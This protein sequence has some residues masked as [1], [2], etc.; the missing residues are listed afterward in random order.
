MAFHQVD[1]SLFVPINT[2]DT[3]SSEKWL[4]MY[5]EMRNSAFDTTVW[6]KPLDIRDRANQF[7]TDTVNIWSQFFDYYRFLPAALSTNI[8]FD[9]DTVNNIITD[10][11]GRPGFPYDDFEVFAS[12]PNKN[13]SN[14]GTVT[15]RIG[16]DNIYYDNFNAF[17][18]IN[19]RYMHINF[20]EGS[21]WHTVQLGSDDYITITYPTPDKYP[22]EVIIGDRFMTDIYGKSI[23]YMKVNR[24]PLDPNA[25]PNQQLTMHGMNINVYEPCDSNIPPERI[26]NFIFVSGIDIVDFIP[27]Q[28]PN[29]ASH[30]ADLAREGIA[31]LRNFGYRFIVIDWVNSRQNLHTNADNLVALLEDLKCGAIIGD[32]ELTEQFVMMGRSMGGLVANLALLKMEVAGYTSNCY[33]DK[34][35]NVRLLVT[36]DAP[37]QGA[38]IPMSVQK[39]ATALKNVASPVMLILGFPLDYF[40]AHDLFLDGDAAKQMLRQ[41]VSTESVIFPHTYNPHQMHTDLMNDI[42]SMGGRPVNCKVVATSNG[43]MLGNGQTRYWDGASRVAGDRLLDKEFT[44]SG[45]ILGIR[46]NFYG[47]SAILNTNPNGVGSLGQISAGRWWIKIR[48]KWFGLRIKTGYNSLFSTYWEGDM[49]PVSTSAG[50]VYDYNWGLLDDNLLG[51]NYQGNGNWTRPLERWGINGFTGSDGFHWCFIPTASAL[52]LSKALDVPYDNIPMASFMPQTPFDVI[53]GVQNSVQMIT[54]S[55][56]QGD[57]ELN[58]YVRNSPHIHIKNDTLR[59]PALFPTTPHDMFYTQSNCGETRR[60]RVLN[61]EVGDNELYLENQILPCQSSF[62]VSE[63]IYVNERSPFYEYD[64]HPVDPRALQSVYSKDE[65]FIITGSGFAELFTNSG[66][67]LYNP[68]FT[69]PYTTPF[70]VPGFKP[71]CANFGTFKTIAPGEEEPIYKFNIQ[72]GEMTIFPNPTDNNFVMKFVPLSEGLLTYEIIDMVGKKIH[73]SSANVR[74]T[75]AVYYLPVQLNNQLPMGQYIIK[76]K[77]N[78]QL[79]TNKLI[80][81]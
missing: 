47:A 30:Y 55:T 74:T 42:S 71:C 53:M 61:R 29:A 39:A 38:H 67:V 23:S 11:P 44:L 10:K 81:K 3:I 56:N 37:H 19:G 20:H 76:A 77:L 18:G 60:I 4:L 59:D 25:I 33:T 57:F 79:Y 9:F 40:D 68:P 16:G 50:G 31:D 63:A 35:H 66:N 5:S 13:I 26:K 72:A 22:I 78:E 24:P 80:I 64:G 70:I 52:G 54:P 75:D 21:G 45:T 49:L 12:A 36:V 27:N 65:P 1:S 34:Q 32:Y 43:N 6:E 46:I 17:T 73:S 51:L 2:D 15:Y 7:G 28:G 48:L 8:Y 41:H 69:G 14:L 58:P 62:S